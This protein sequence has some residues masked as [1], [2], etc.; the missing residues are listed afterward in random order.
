[1]LCGV[2]CRIPGAALAMPASEQGHQLY[3]AHCAACHGPTGRGNGPAAIALDVPPRD[4]RDEPFRYISTLNGVPTE[5]DLRQTI[6]SGRHF[7]AMP[8]RPNLRDVEVHLL[9][10]YVREINRLGWAE[11]LAREFAD[12]EDMTPE[13]I[14]EIALE[15]VTPDEPIPVPCPPPGFHSDTEVGRELYLNSCASCHG[16]TG[17]GDGMEK[18]K[19][20]R[21]RP[22]AVR[23]LTT[24]QFRGGVGPDEVFKRIRCGVPGTPM[25]AQVGLTDEEVWQLVHYVRYLAGWR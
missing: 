21:G 4:F 24:G 5:E 22:I 3:L 6:R 14:E 1:M 11:R 12:D 2:S 8:A 18:P 19:D 20:D 23:D 15:R 17:Q 10:E 16:P 9:A 13:E 7:G 25:P